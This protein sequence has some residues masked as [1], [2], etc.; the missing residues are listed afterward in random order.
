MSR[1][2]TPDYVLDLKAPTRDFLCPLNANTY[3]I[4]FLSFTVE[5]Y[6]TKHLIFEVSRDR[7]PKMELQ[8]FNPMDE[9]S[10]RKI[11]YQFSE[12]V[13]RLPAIKTSL[14]FSVGPQPVE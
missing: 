1:A 5:D 12:D 4:E 7:P 6:D 11:K 2:I 9:N 8:D 10:M 14:I 13:L 3:G